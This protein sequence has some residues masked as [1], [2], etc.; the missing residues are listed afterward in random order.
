MPPT[1]DAARL[2]AAVA[3]L[4]LVVDDAACDTRV[5]AVP[6]YGEPR[7]TSTVTLRGGGLAGR[8]EHVG[9]TPA[10]HAAFAGTCGDVPRGRTSV[11][12]WSAAL[13]ASVRHPYD[14]AALEAAA[15]D[16]ACRQRRT[17][18]FRLAGVAPR[19]VRYVVSYARLA[20]P[21]AALAT[22]DE[23]KLDVDP[24]W[25][26]DVLAALARSGRVAIVDFK[27]R[28]GGA[29]RVARALPAAL[30]EDPP[31]PW[32]PVV[33]ART[34]LD[35]AIVAP[36]DVDAADPPPAA[37][38]LKP[39]RIGGPLAALDAAARAAQRAIPVYLGG[40]FE[41]GIGRAQLH[42]LAALLASD[43]PNDVAPIATDGLPAA[44]PPRLVVP[45]ADGFG[46]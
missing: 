10:A 15:I 34:S 31:L 36:D 8:G 17:S 13:A 9:W 32:P 21:S 25:S 29:E 28:D 3:A 11:G 12:D 46:A 16:L 6:S 18:L 2:H 20:D 26:D 1:P 41:I 5:A 19:P 23:L 4:E 45:D 35:A 42:V 39:A 22:G 33:R 43:G 14:R 24:A 38:N 44:R 30:L 37:V 40:M 7:P 27:G